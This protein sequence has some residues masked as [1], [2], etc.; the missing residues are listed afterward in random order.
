MEDSDEKLQFEYTTTS[1]SSEDLLTMAPEKEKTELPIIEGQNIFDFEIDKLEEKPWLRPGADISDYFNYGFDENTWKAYCARQREIREDIG[2]P[3]FH[4]K[5]REEKKKEDY[6]RGDY[7]RDDY[8]RSQRQNENRREEARRDFE[9]RD[10]DRNRN[11][12]RDFGRRDGYRRDYD[13][14][15]P[16]KDR[17]NYRRR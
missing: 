16:R 3:A 8:N 12:R 17:D 5:A 14:R 7:K 6:R 2:A 10:L 4:F 1:S 11:D 15:D 13:D 9:R